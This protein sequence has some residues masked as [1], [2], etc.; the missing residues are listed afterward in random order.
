VS[1]S[2]S[3]PADHPQRNPPLDPAEHARRSM[4]GLGNLVERITPWLFE[5]GS[6]IFGG[7][8]AFNLVVISALIT[9][10]PVDAAILISVTVFACALPLNVAGI[11]LLRLIK[12]MKGIGVDDLTLQAFQD[13]GFPDIEAYF[14]PPRERESHHKRRA[15]IALG[16][17]LGIAAPSI[18]LT[19][20]GLVAALWHVA[21]WIGVVLL[22][23]VILSIALVTVVIAH[24]MPPESEAEKELKRHYMEHRTR[25][26]KE[27]SKAERDR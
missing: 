20:T 3:T 12:D 23:M 5:V 2:D 21:W 19:L 25:Q 4:K 16:Y 22:A 1:Q 8:I 17:S 27:Q 14:P 15:T 24:S 18:A 10:R 13:A 6:W 7:L 11:F 9:V 26:R